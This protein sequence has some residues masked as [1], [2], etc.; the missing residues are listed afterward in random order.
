MSQRQHGQNLIRVALFGMVNSYLVRE[1]DGYTAVDTGLSG[2][3]ARMVRA[4]QAA[5]LPIRRIVLTHAHGDHVGGLDALKA[6][7]PEAEVLIS[8]RDARLL[9]GDRT[10]DPDEPQ[11]PVRG[12]L[13]P[14]HTQP[15]RLLGDGDRIGPLQVV[16]APGHTPGHLALLDTRDGTLI[17]GDAWQTLGGLAVAGD[18]RL[19]FP[20]PALATW[21]A[22]TALASARRLA[23]LHPARLAVGHGPVLE[24]PEAAMRAAIARLERRLQGP[25]GA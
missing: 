18:L 3:A 5:G 2:S 8:A 13:T 21:H 7:Y 15:D 9:G 23:D 1:E 12:S 10:L 6:A 4:A 11:S 16:A 17:V 24:H 20:L 14:V 25:P 19:L 22:P